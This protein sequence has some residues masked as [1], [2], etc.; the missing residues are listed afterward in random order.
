ML[1][2]ASFAL[3]VVLLPWIGGC[4]QS[5][6]ATIDPDANPD[7]LPYRLIEIKRS[8]KNDY[9]LR[10]GSAGA[11]SIYQ[12]QNNWRPEDTLTAVLFKKS[13][14]EGGNTLDQQNFKTRQLDSHYAYDMDGDDTS[15]VLVSYKTDDS[16]YFEIVNPYRGSI[17]RRLVDVGVD[18]N[19]NGHW[20]GDL[21]IDDVI[22]INGDGRADVVLFI[23]AGYDLVPRQVVCLDI[24]NDTLLWRCDVP[25]QPGPGSIISVVDS[26]GSPLL[27]VGGA[28]PCNG[29][30]VNGMSDCNSNLICLNA[31]GDIQWHRVT[32]PRHSGIHPQPFKYGE[33][34]RN[35]I[36]SQFYTSDREDRLFS[37]LKVLDLSGRTLDSI[38]FDNPIRRQRVFRYPDEND[39]SIFVSTDGFGLTILNRN[40]E[41]TRTVRFPSDFYVDYLGDVVGDARK[42]IVATDGTSIYLLDGDFNL[43]AKASRG[44]VPEVLGQAIAGARIILNAHDQNTYYSIRKNSWT[45]VI[46]YKYRNHLIV[47]LSI[48]IAG[49]ITSA[50]YQRQLKVKGTVIEEQRRSLARTLTTL[51]ETQAQLVQAERY[52]NTKDIAGSFAHEIRNVIFPARAWLSKLRAGGA[53]DEDDSMARGCARAEQSLSKAYD[54]TEKILLFSKLEDHVRREEVNLEQ[55]VR[56]VV[57]ELATRI[58]EQSVAIRISIDGDILVTGDRSYLD[59][60]WRSLL[61]NSLD[62]LGEKARDGQITITAEDRPLETVVTFEDNGCGIK[63]S[64]IGRVFDSFF[65]TKPN[66]GIGLGLAFVRKILNMMGGS[67]A[68]ESEVGRFTRFTIS[69]PRT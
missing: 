2:S 64:D 55:S 65:S 61:L 24:F 32:G 47:L 28:S 25:D 4:S 67:I 50:F 58:A 12:V 46:V 18:R 37:F 35:C 20:D 31:R 6:H 9:P 14:L 54:L 42:E 51:R 60:V 19:H 56:S 38:L 45:K 10:I 34:G 69:L 59:I 17:Y 49:L 3:I 8:S 16:L 26:T 11:T 30:D 39:E 21:F 53:V 5:R 41:V 40:L 33:T 48:L 62:A 7:Y 57:E 13:G 66:I 22:D 36:I 44:G 43:L 1:R 68:V 15:E 27:I 63:D 23:S 52:R 29:Y